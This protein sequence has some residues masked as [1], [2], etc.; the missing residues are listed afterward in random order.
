MKY[1][2]LSVKDIFTVWEDEKVPEMEVVMAAQ[3]C[4]CI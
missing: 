2:V 4:G 1:K 3:H